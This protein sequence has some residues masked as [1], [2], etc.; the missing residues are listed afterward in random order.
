M[1]IIENNFEWDYDEITISGTDYDELSHSYPQTISIPQNSACF[2]VNTDDMCS[3]NDSPC[4]GWTYNGSPV[5][6]RIQF[7]N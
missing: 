6:L 5:T 7:W 1:T 3:A 4:D 2:H